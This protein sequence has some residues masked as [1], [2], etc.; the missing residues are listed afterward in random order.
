MGWGIE[1]EEEGRKRG[2]QVLKA[3]AGG[4]WR[5]RMRRAEMKARNAGGK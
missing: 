2:N 3:N 5:T 1:V 4:K